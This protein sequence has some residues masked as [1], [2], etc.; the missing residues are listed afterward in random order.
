MNAACR[1]QGIRQRG[2]FKRQQKM[3]LRRGLLK[4][5]EEDGSTLSKN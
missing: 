2:G 4:E 5:L 3:Y 1:V